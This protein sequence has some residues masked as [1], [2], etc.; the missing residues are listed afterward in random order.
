[1]QSFKNIHLGS[2]SI[3]LTNVPNLERPGHIKLKIDNANQDVQDEIVAWG[4]NNLYPQDFYNKKFLR[5]GAAVGGINL[6]KSTHYGNGFEIYK[7]VKDGKGEIVLREQLLADFPEI[8]KFIRDNRLG[9]FWYE[10][11]TDQSLFHIAFTSHEISAN[12][13]QIVRVKRLKAA[14]CRFAP[15]NKDGFV[16]YVYVNSDWSNND[17]TNTVKIPY[18]D[19][20]MTAEE[21]KEYCREKKIFNFCTSTCYPLVDESYY[22]KTDW[23]AVDRS[24]WIDV[25]NSVPELKQALFQ[26]QMHFKYIVYVSDFYF[27]SYYKDEW[28]DFDADKRQDMREKLATAIDEHMSGNKSAGRSLTS[29]IF[30]ENGKF[31]KGIEISPVDNKLKDGSYLPDASAANSEILFAI[32]VNPAIIGAGTP[33]GSNLSGS[34]SDIREGY[35][36]LSAS[37]VP[38]R[39]MTLEDWELWRDFNGWDE[40][41]IGAF[42]SV[43]LTTLDKNPDGQEEIVN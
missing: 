41:L 32:G 25:A 12:G 28:D 29:P 22:P 10:R 5:N 31:V 19:S 3:V 6:L 20:D 15:Q 35:T 21:I 11:I 24:G 14:H 27:E 36:V 4:S 23:H 43:N 37:L 8:K 17:S 40:D 38:R 16:E 42:P 7:K 2:S 34:G 26:N 13:N 39:V 9:R 18:M 1:M 33:G 30:D